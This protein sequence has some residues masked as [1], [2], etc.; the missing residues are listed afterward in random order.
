[1]SRKSFLYGAY[2]AGVCVLSPT[3]EGYHIVDDAT[4]TPYEGWDDTIWDGLGLL[5]YTFLPHFDSDHPESPAIS[6]E[7]EYCKENGLPYK[8][9][10]DGE[11]FVLNASS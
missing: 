7:L 8:T 5:N 11:V 10:R 3:L 9:A 6:Q 1:M 4:A 2:S